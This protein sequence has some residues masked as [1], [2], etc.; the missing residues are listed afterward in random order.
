[1]AADLARMSEREYFAFVA[2]RLGMF[3]AGSRLAG[4]E[5]FLDGYD[6]HALRHG[7]PGLTGWRE[8]LVTRRG[9]ECGHG[10]AAQVRHITLSE[11]SGQRELTRE[12]EARVVKVLFE[13][14]DEF[15]TARE[16]PVAHDSMGDVS[17]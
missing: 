2:E 11:G 5:A 10:W 17:P 15:L 4:I 16:A 3:V 13:L 9:Q 8:W 12:E 7:G 1:M 6:Q 14:L